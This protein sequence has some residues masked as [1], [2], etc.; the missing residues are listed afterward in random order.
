MEE[1]KK[2]KR[3]EEKMEETKRETIESKQ[4]KRGREE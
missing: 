4:E 2:K 3:G 1:N